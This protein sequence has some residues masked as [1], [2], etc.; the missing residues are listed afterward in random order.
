MNRLEKNTLG[1]FDCLKGVII[2][3]VIC[4]HTYTDI[5][6][7][8]QIDT[9][10]FPMRF[11]NNFQGIA[12]AVLFAISGYQFKPIKTKKMFKN[13]F[14]MLIWPCFWIF[15]VSL[16]LLPLVN[17]MFQRSIWDGALPRV[18]GFLLQ[19]VKYGDQWGIPVFSLQSMWYFFALFYAWLLLSLVT[20]RFPENRVV[21]PVSLL[22]LAGIFLG[23]RYHVLP[24]CINQSLLGLG[25]LY[26]GW[27]L[28]KGNYL[29]RQY[30]WKL[31]LI[32]VILFF[33]ALIFG[34]FNI[35]S[36]IFK[37]GVFDY[38]ANLCGAFLILKAYLYLFRPDCV[39]YRPVMFWGRNSLILLS[40][41]CLEQRTFHWGETII[42]QKEYFWRNFVLLFPARLLALFLLF[43]LVRRLNMLL[44]SLRRRE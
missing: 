10:P 12:M 37:L 11:L 36:V 40:L 41:H 2:L 39:W 9:L 44:Q 28:K 13:Q 21:W 3:Y 35:G 1:M 31:Y 15:A 6:A 14:Q 23:S 20:H 27:R 4:V 7:A 5:L 19:T 8:S 34:D 42:L 33:I 16:F 30:S 18:A 29:F 24:F 38:A 22:T 43:S 32:T 17:L 25:F 26:L